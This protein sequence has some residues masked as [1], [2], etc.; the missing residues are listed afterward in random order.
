VRNVRRVITKTATEEP[1][2]T[3]PIDPPS[4]VEIF[5]P[6]AVYLYWSD[7]DRNLVCLCPDES[8]PDLVAKALSL[9]YNDIPITQRN[10]H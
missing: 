7:G 9:W 10:N 2:V 8:M 4:K 5:R 6:F 3:A 1:G